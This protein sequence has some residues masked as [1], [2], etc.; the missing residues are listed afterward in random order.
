MSVNFRDNH[1][2]SEY[3]YAP[4]NHVIDRSFEVV[5]SL[6][7]TSIESS[8]VD[9]LDELEDILIAF[10]ERF[11]SALNPE[12]IYSKVEHEHSH[13]IAAHLAGF[14]VIKY[15][16]AY[17]ESDSGSVDWVVRTTPLH[18]TR[19]VTK[20][21]FASIVA[22]PFKMSLSDREQLDFLGYKSAWDVAR[23]VIAHN[24]ANPKTTLKIPESVF[25]L[26]S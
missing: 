22:A 10:S 5:P 26:F 21:S 17:F 2:L 16:V 23:K 9:N 14:S 7:I 15:G 3:R 20:L 25:S 6:P 12:R 24:K 18:P 11:R 4:D 8:M 1:Y 19:D 13:G